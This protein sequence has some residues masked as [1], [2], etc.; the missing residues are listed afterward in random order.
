MKGEGGGRKDGGEEKGRGAGDVYTFRPQALVHGGVFFLQPVLAFF[1]GAAEFAVL[2]ASL[3]SR[4]L[5][6]SGETEGERVP[7]GVMSRLG[8]G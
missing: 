7:P 2:L 8:R 1:H 6:L 3:V 5:V 4:V